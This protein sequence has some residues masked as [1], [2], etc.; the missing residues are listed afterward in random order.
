[1]NNV[2]FPLLAV[3]LSGC[4]T[5]FNVPPEETLNLIVSGIS[6]MR[7]GA[8]DNAEPC[9]LRFPLQSVCIEYDENNVVPDALLALQ[10]NLRQVRVDSDVYFSGNMPLS[11]AY[12]LRYRMARNWS[13]R[14]A[15]KEKTQYLEMAD[16]FLYQQNKLISSAHFQLERFSFEKWTSTSNKL[17][18]VVDELVCKKKG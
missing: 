9:E 16:L 7:G 13:G 18:S 12:T 3:C 6:G 8:D 17:R 15:S 10:D 14:L 4:V 1:M 5:L 11:C 2:W